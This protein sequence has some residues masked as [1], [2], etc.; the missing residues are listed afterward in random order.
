MEKDFPRGHFEELLNEKAGEYKMYPTERVWNSI[1]HR[2][3]TR[4]KWHF[5]G[6]GTFALMILAGV[7]VLMQDN[8]HAPSK[9]YSKTLSATVRGTRNGNTPGAV[10]LASS[11]NSD[12]LSHSLSLHLFTGETGNGY[13]PPTDYLFQVK[14]I[15]QAPPTVDDGP[16]FMARRSEEPAVKPLSGTMEAGALSLHM[17]PNS[18]LLTSGQQS[19][20]DHASALSTSLK[21]LIDPPSRYSWLFH[22]QPSVS[23]RMLKSKAAITTSNYGVIVVDN[24]GYDINRLVDQRPSLGFE[25]GSDLLYALNSR[26]SLKVGAQFNYSRYTAEAISSPSRTVNVTLG[27]AGTGGIPSQT[28]A[29]SSVYTNSQGQPNLT[30]TWI[31]DQRVELSVPVGAEFQVVRAQSFSWVVAGTVQPT[32]ILNAKAFLLSADYK[33]YV[34]EPNL[35]RRWNANLGAETFLRFNRGDLQIQIGPQFR[36]QMLPS[37]ISSYPISE[38]LYDIGFKI[39]IVRSFR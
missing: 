32:Y 36:Y 1:Y 7:F 3:H 9:T 15:Y 37:F 4:R 20:A 11:T 14:D 19:L 16:G 21:K 12:K 2:L 25:V 33:S 22:F 30:A 38:H 34:Q 26:L 13:L 23:F 31:P 17:I 8:T 18:P 24:N 28:V 27:G 35:L 10:T 6:G 39:G 5:I 29:T